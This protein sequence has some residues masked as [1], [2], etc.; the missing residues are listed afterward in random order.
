MTARF[1]ARD[2]VAIVGLGATQYTRSGTRTAP[3]LA[4]EAAQQAITDAGLKPE[5]I[6]GL[7]GSSWNACPPPTYLQAALGIPELTWSAQH[8]VPFATLLISAMNAVAAGVC[9]TALVYTSLNRM[10]GLSQS[11]ASDPFRA[12]MVNNLG[13]LQWIGR[14]IPGLASSY[15]GWMQRYMHE[16]G[17][18]REDFG[19]LA[20]SN[21]SYAADNP[22]A[23]FRE[24]LTMEA[25]L[26]ARMVENLG[27]LQL[28]GRQIPGL[29]SSYSGWMQRYMYEYGAKREDFGRLAISNRSYAADNPRAIFHEPL[30]MDEYLGARMVREPM[31]MLDMDIP[32]DGADAVVV[33]TAER[34]RDLK[35][36][37]VLIHAAT[38]GQVIHGEDDQM[39]GLRNLSKHAVARN[40]WPRSELALADM[41]IFFP[42]DGF[43][44]IM[45]NDIEVAGYCGPGEAPDF[46]KS[47]WDAKT[48]RLKIDGKI[49][50]N[51]HGGALSE[52]GNQ[53]AGHIR[54][55]T[56]QLRGDAGARQSP[57]PV[58][59][60]LLISG[61]LFFNTVGLVLRTA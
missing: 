11:A 29:A 56:T 58:K 55:A 35:K 13:G 61:S 16:Y 54:E 4:I 18:C 41:D 5:D 3:A 44:V 28:T 48:N 27:G 17:A 36:P 9:E 6:D 37:P 32:I 7:I 42:Y 45:M 47:H 14:Q 26:A 51:P 33:T 30:T 53:S 8:I 20:I 34:A 23:I 49:L 40:L 15:S 19:R 39:P 2:K 12:R 46:V 38:Y 10:P 22:R 1:P 52:G 21:R 43:S 60:A 31:C 57:H 24:P 25:Y 50:V 59:N